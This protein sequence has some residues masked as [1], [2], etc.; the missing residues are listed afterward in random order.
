MLS[1]YTQQIFYIPLF[2]I[3]VENWEKK[4]R[5]LLN[6]FDKTNLDKQGDT[7]FSDYF[8]QETSHIKNI[9]II[10]RDELEIFCTEFDQKSCRVDSAW[11]EHSITGDFHAVHNHGQIGYSAVCY[12]N[13]DKNEHTPTHFVSP[14]ANFDGGEI[15]YHIPEVDEGD[16]IIFPSSLLHYT[17]PNMSEKHRTIVSFNLSF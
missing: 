11:F 3:S 1:N 16:L 13:Y 8:T 15:M 12:V 4:K 6:M 9:S 14:F 17:K 5:I 7:V 10:F 2:K